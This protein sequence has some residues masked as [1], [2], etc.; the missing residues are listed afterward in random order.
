MES[1]IEA[2]SRSRLYLNHRTFIKEPIIIQ[3]NSVWCVPL[4]LFCKSEK[5]QMRIF[6]LCCSCIFIAE[7]HPYDFRLRFIAT[8]VYDLYACSARGRCGSTVNAKIDCWS[9]LAKLISSLVY[10]SRYKTIISYRSLVRSLPT[11]DLNVTDIK[12]GSKSE[13]V[14]FRQ[15]LLSLI[16]R[17]CPWSFI[18][19]VANARDPG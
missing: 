18:S 12:A 16:I 19:N 17:S 13:L 10:H 3:I 14:Q 4:W 15:T 5:R 1:W 9:L 2:R 11:V 6:F 7:H 8:I